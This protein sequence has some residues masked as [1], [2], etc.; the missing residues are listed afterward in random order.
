MKKKTSSSIL[1]SIA[2]LFLTTV[3]LLPSTAWSQQKAV[4]FTNMCTPFGTP[5]YTQAVA[6]EEVFK[7][8]GSW[9]KWKAQETPGAMYMIRYTV[10]NQKKM[11][12]GQ[13]PQVGAISSVGVLPFVVEGRRPFTKFKIPT[14]RA[15]FS[16]P[17][18]TTFFVTFDPNIK[19]LRDLEGKKVGIAEKSRPFQGAIALGPYFRKGLKNWKKI[20]WQFL[21]AG[22]SRDALLNNKIDAHYATFM[23]SAKV[24]ADGSFYSDAMAPGPAVM[25]LMNSG[26][27]LYFIPW[28]PV[29]FKAAYDFSKDMIAHPIL[30]KK[31]AIKGIDA[32]IWGRLTTGILQVDETLPD[33]VLQEIVRVRYQY[34]AELGKYHGT[35]TLLPENPYPVGTPDE[36]VHSGLR[37]AMKNLGIPIPGE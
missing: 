2:V 37:K 20:K 17:S 12:S 25:Q 19:S 36:L 24:A 13:I 22:N 5:M 15:A 1:K 29:V 28:D 27:K 32:D 4:A 18:F 31:G 30:V 9:V 21:G 8:A 6:F 23:G 14:A 33:D 11:A 26:R 35:L 16:M 10:Q 34:R 3:L 7:K